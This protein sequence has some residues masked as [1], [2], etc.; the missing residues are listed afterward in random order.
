MKKSP[1]L[2]VAMK[3]GMTE[4]PGRA[5]SRALAK[6][7]QILE[8]LANSA[9]PLA[10][11]EIARSIDLGKASAL[12]LLQTL[13]VTGYARQFGDGSY[14]LNRSWMQTTTQDWLQ[15]LLTAAKPEMEML[16]AEVA[17]T[18]SLA[19]L[20]GDHIRVIA[21]LESP[22]HIR[23]SNYKDRI[24]A[25]YASSLGK[26]ISAYLPADRLQN[27][28]QVYGIYATTEKTITD[29]ALIRKEMQRTRTRG[30]ASEYEETVRGGCCFGA[31][32]L[33]SAE[34]RAAISISL[35]ADRLT[36]ELE[37]QIPVLL[38]SAAGN[39]SQAMAADCGGAN[40]S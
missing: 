21:T 36:P 16:N 12:R 20:M 40:E 4:D 22:R 26:A 28:L 23:M 1:A 38:C 34:V 14:A 24:L 10:L 37:E 31:P 7:V 5:D 9:T 27:L 32:I 3:S 2:S 35:P 13:L 18:V 15:H 33:T 29:P 6:G 8:V 19:A 39:I 25:P 17:E 11:A 30:F